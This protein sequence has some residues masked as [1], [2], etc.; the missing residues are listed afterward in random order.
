MPNER[1]T[2]KIAMALR[3]SS[4]KSAFERALDHGL[5]LRPQIGVEAELRGRVIIFDVSAD[6]ESQHAQVD[7]CIARFLMRGARR[8]AAVRRASS[9]SRRVQRAS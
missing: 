4:G 7:R 3:S 8:L 5:W 9:A 1:S 6:E 2:H